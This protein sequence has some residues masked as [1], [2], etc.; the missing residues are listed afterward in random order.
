MDRAKALNLLRSRARD[1][2]TWVGGE[3]DLSSIL[4]LSGLELEPHV[5]SMEAFIRARF[6]DV[7]SGDTDWNDPSY[8]KRKEM[9]KAF[10]VLGLDPI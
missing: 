9:D 2:K 5:K 3:Y 6:A 4:D 7:A 8:F 10:Q 1:F